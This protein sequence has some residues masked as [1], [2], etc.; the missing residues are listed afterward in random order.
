M[1]DV[2]QEILDIL[3]TIANDET[4]Y[5]IRL[6]NIKSICEYAKSLKEHN[7]LIEEKLDKEQD[8]NRLLRSENKLLRDQINNN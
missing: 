6:G 8:Y 4:S 1:W 5:V 2:E 7:T 3:K